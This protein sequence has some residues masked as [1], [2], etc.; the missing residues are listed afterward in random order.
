MYI[1]QP[2]TKQ[3]AKELGV[4]IKPSANKKKKIDVFKDDKKIA[5]IGAIGF[6]DFPTLLKTDPSIA[7]ERRRL[8]HIRHNKDNGANGFY[9]KNLLW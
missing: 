6:N 4:T 5:S 2:Y 1:I 7:N 9:A 8:Y 3:R